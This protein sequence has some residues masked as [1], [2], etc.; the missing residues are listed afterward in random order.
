MK[1]IQKRKESVGNTLR[2]VSFAPLEKA[3]GRRQTRKPFARRK[4]KGRNSHFS[5]RTRASWN[6]KMSILKFSLAATQLQS[7]LH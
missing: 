2:G 3:A 6:Q 7:D 5:L 1:Q 4:A